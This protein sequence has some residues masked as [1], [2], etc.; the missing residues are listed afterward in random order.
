MPTILVVDDLAAVRRAYALNLGDLGHLVFEAE[1]GE[2]A[3][4]LTSMHHFDLV[5]TDLTMDGMSGIELLETLR[6]R[7]LRVKV[8]LIS[9]L[10]EH[11]REL[12]AQKWDFEK[13]LSKPVELDD[14]IATVSMALAK[15]GSDLGRGKALPGEVA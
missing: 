15:P 1:S 4:R 3:L 6:E 8:V 11:Y 7:G 14:L 12:F 5:I 2:E 13:I 10:N 9:A